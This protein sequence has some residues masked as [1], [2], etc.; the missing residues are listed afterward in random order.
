MS[1]G[2]RRPFWCLAVILLAAGALALAACSND[3]DGGQVRAVSVSPRPMT[4]DAGR[5][6]DD[7]D[8][9]IGFIPRP[10]GSGAAGG[11]TKTPIADLDAD[12]LADLCVDLDARFAAR[13]DDAQAAR[14]ACTL[15]ALTAAI[16]LDAD[17]EPTLDSEACENEVQSCLSV[18]IGE[19]SAVDCAGLAER[20]RGCELS[21]A[22]LQACFDAVVIRVAGSLDTVSCSLASVADVDA[23]LTGLVASG[24]RECQPVASECPRL[25]PVS[26]PDRPELPAFDGCADTCESALDGLCDDGGDGS[27]ADTCVFGSDCTDCGLR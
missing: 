5:D 9:G 27:E 25:L 3:D 2:P 1:A 17:G 21:V 26:G 20:A 11:P 16:Q 7:E 14:F 22:E 10:S 23:L 12:Q 13:V 19:G 4:G 18:P 6:D 15:F 8:G 24:L